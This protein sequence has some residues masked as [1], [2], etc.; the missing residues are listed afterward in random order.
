MSQDMPPLPPHTA[1]LHSNG[2]VCLDRQPTDV[3]FWPTGLHTDE[4]MYAYA[5]EH[6]AP[7]L[8]RIAELERDATRLDWMEL[9]ADGRFC[10][11]DRITSAHGKFNGLPTLRAAIDKAMQPLQEGEPG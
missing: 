9:R 11:I 7:L 4:A 1:H 10:N 3:V 8:A 2:D 6:A 5:K